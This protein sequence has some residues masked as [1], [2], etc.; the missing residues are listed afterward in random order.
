MYAQPVNPTGHTYHSQM[1]NRVPQHAPPPMMGGATPAA[2]V[3]A[4]QP[5]AQPVNA[6]AMANQQPSNPQNRPPFV[7]A[8]HDGA[9]A[10]RITKLAEYTARNGTAF[11]EQVR[12]KQRQNQEYAFLHGGEGSNY[13]AWCRFC[14][15]R[16]LD[17]TL[18]L[19]DD[20]VD[21]LPA[22]TGKN[23]GGWSSGA[24][25]AFVPTATMQPRLDSHPAA[26]ALPQQFPGGNFPAPPPTP[27][28]LAQVPSNI[29]P[30]AQTQA[31]GGAPARPEHVAQSN[32][33]CGPAAPGGVPVSMVHQSS[34]QFGGSHPPVASGATPPSAPGN[35]P[36]PPEVAQ[37]F[38]YVLHVLQGSQV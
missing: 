18:P 20:W 8:P 21:P 22:H 23:G 6:Y 36:L 29:P 26:D 28:Q 13:Y 11:E 10:L 2:P 32:M 17:H 16:G 1:I 14:A 9:L 5:Y 37:N 24:V 35:V 3:I 38:A 15:F 25:P 12:A 34:P 4:H 33:Y 19:P 7:P 30:F 31:G 27:Q